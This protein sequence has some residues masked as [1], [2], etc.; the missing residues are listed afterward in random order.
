M[1]GGCTYLIASAASV[2]ELG[3][4]ACEV[5]IGDGLA[6]VTVCV[7]VCVI[8]AVPEACDHVACSTIVGGDV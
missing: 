7:T 6:D 3:G 5:V 4:Y 2:D 1:T 8:G